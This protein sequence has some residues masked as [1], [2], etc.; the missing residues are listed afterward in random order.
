MPYRGAHWWIIGLFPIIGIAFWPNYWSQFATAPFTLHLHGITASSWLALTGAQSWSIHRRSFRLHRQVGLATFVLVPLFA[1]GGALAVQSMAA[2][3]AGQVTPFHAAF[4]A[5]LGT[6][7]A[8]AAPVFV[9]LVA[10]GLSA[11]RD[12]H[13]HAA[14]L[15]SIVFLVLPPVL[16]RLVGYVPGIRALSDSSGLHPFVFGFHGGQLIA[17]AIALAFAWLRPRGRL[18]FLI[19]A[20]TCMVQIVAFETIGRTAFWESAM[21]AIAILPAF[22]LAVPAALASLALL[23]W[24]WRRVPARVNAPPAATL[25]HSR[26]GEGAA[27]TPLA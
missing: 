26:S 15:L 12:I 2:L 6:A 1:A 10:L 27:P 5:R 4:G 20:A 11:R 8:I 14:S 25:P 3:H 17:A 13:L 24:S 21:A 9:G 16:G 19:V 18:P 7:D 23:W 22:T